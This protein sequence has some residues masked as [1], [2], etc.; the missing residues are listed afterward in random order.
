ML[1]AFKQIRENKATVPIILGMAALFLA[2]PHQAHAWSLVGLAWSSISS[3]LVS[4]YEIIV[5][6]IAAF[7]LYLVGMLMDSAITLSINTAYIFS[8]SPAVNLGWVIIRD[9]ANICFIFIL[10]YISIT[11]IVQG[12]NANFGIKNML[13][14]VIIAAILINFSLFFTKVIVDVSNVFGNW[15]YGGV[16]KTLVVNTT[17]GS[18]TNHTSLSGLIAT[19]LGIAGFWSATP[20]ANGS[21]WL[22]SDFITVFLRLAVV[23]IAIYIFAYVT[24]LFLARAIEILFLLVFSPIGFMGEVL[25]QIKKYADEWWS[26]LS[27][28]AIFPIAFLLMLYISLQFIN[29]L[30]SLN[31][32]ALND[33]AVKLPLGVTISVSQYFQYFL[34]IFLLGACLKMAKQY[35]GEVGEALGGLAQSLAKTAV[36]AA[37]TY[38]TGG[39]AFLGR[40]TIGMGA[41]KLAENDTLNDAASGRYGRLAQLGGKAALGATRQTAK[42]SFDVRATKVFGT[43]SG[44]TLPK[45]VASS[46]GK[47]GGKGGYEAMVKDLGKT[48]KGYAK[49]FGDSPEGIARRMAYAKSRKTSLLDWVKVGQKARVKTGEGVAAEAV[50]A[51]TKGRT[52]KAKKDAQKIMAQIVQEEIGANNISAAIKTG[53]PSE[54]DSV[55]RNERDRLEDMSSGARKDKEDPAEDLINKTAYKQYDISRLQKVTEDYTIPADERMKAQEEMEKLQKDYDETATKLTESE[56]ADLK[57]AQEKIEKMETRNKEYVEKI[58]AVLKVADATKK[59]MDADDLVRHVKDKIIGKAGKG[60]KKGK[61]GEDATGLY[62][63]LAKAR[64]AASEASKAEKEILGEDKKEGGEKKEGGGG[65][66]KEKPKG[67]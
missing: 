54:I 29:S 44:A 6:P 3:V 20:N 8:L 22:T 49:E 4:L 28:A 12:T 51:A 11:T 32:S 21:S 43:L 15:L 19:R 55:L 40:R 65:G 39:L 36:G 5:L 10:I 41:A 7:V 67:E 53:K 13:T 27:K 26:E 35:S 59:R 24:I 25:P 48:E 2:I 66:E 50:T 47:A 31:L 23:L 30:G 17:N 1:R 18:P 56:K 42:S 46:I 52:Q 38:A 61:A 63:E 62:A 58:D 14:K 33:N 45:E 37:T 34:I 16:E 60:G 57:K 64:K 9:I